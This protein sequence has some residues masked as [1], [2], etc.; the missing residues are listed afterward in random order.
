M[1]RG[2]VYRHRS[3]LSFNFQQSIGH[4]REELDLSSV[5]IETDEG[6]LE[7]WDMLAKLQ[8]AHCA[9]N[10]LADGCFDPGFPFCLPQMDPL[11]H[12][13]A[14]APTR[15]FFIAQSSRF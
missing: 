7:V 8:P 15:I 6:Q 14:A 2:N 3:A 13:K 10:K 5:N 1:L 11:I 12:P 9:A 4:P